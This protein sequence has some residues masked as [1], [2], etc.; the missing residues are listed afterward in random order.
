MIVTMTIAG[1]VF[2]TGARAAIF[3]I[4]KTSKHRRLAFSFWRRTLRQRQPMA[5]LTT[6]ETWTFSS[7]GNEFVSQISSCAIHKRLRLTTARTVVNANSTEDVRRSQ[8]EYATV[9]F[10]TFFPT[11]ALDSVAV[12]LLLIVA[13]SSNFG[14]LTFTRPRFADISQQVQH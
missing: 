8:A 6:P 9:M 11:I 3:S 10:F 4:S 2:Q 12:S 1:L 7:G 5:V 13:V 14:R